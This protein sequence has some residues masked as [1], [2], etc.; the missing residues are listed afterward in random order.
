[1]CINN[2]NGVVRNREIANSREDS[3][4]SFHCG[5]VVLQVGLVLPPSGVLFYR[6]NAVR[7]IGCSMP[8]VFVFVFCHHGMRPL[9]VTN[10]FLLHSKIHFFFG[11]DSFLV[12]F[13]VCTGGTCTSFLHVCFRM[14]LFSP[15]M[16][17]AGA[18]IETLA[19]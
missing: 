8:N 9:C 17:L 12:L 11:I 14:R 13:G 4:D 2:I 3:L 10:L 5:V 6:D 18:C 15:C 7:Y 1:M 16:H 19:C